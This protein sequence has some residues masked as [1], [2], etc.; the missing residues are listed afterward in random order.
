MPIAE[1]LQGLSLF[2]GFGAERIDDLASRAYLRSFP[3][4]A[5]LV[6]QGDLDASMFVITDGRARVTFHAPGG[7]KEIALLGKGDVVGEISVLTGSARTATVTA[8]EAVTAIEI[9]KASFN[10][11]VAGHRE[12]LEHLASIVEQRRAELTHVKQEAEASE[13]YGRTSILDRLA[14]LFG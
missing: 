13:V 11:V 6:R 7:S 2:D 8:T 3:A 14:H 4:G 1:T 5:A 12:L 9:D 10:A